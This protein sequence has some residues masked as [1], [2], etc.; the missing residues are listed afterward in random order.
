MTKRGLECFKSAYP[1]SQSN[2]VTQFLDCTR[3]VKQVAIAPSS[4]RTPHSPMVLTNVLWYH[5]KSQ[6]TPATL[7][8]TNHLGYNCN[9]KSALPM[10]VSHEPHAHVH[11][12]RSPIAP[13]THKQVKE[14]SKFEELYEALDHSKP[15]ES[16]CVMPVA[17]S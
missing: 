3:P 12:R 15:I 5:T 14:L 9:C 2:D 8:A 16:M 11:N 13:R 1:T 10:Q 4:V 6:Q 7:K 17:R